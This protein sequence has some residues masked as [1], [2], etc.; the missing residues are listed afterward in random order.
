MHILFVCTG[1]QCRSVMAEYLTRAT[2]KAHG[3]DTNITVSSAGT[4]Q[5]PPH[6]ADPMTMELLAGDDID[7]TGHRSTSINQEIISNA[8]VILCFERNHINELSRWNPSAVRKTALF[9]DFVNACEYLHHH[10]SSID[11]PYDVG[12]RE[13]LDD[14]PMIRPFLPRANDTMDPHRQSREVF[15]RV[16]AEIKKG[17]NVIFDSPT[18]STSDT[19]M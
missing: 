6:T 15:V 18:A 19:V 7:A 10:G 9:D 1:N 12:I 16:Y 8:D 4:L 17:I 13:T 11:T 3:T 14:M 5:Y 2:I